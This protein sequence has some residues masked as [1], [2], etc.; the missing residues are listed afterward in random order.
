MPLSLPPLASAPEMRPVV[1]GI[2][3]DSGAG[4]TTLAQGIAAILGAG[5]VALLAADDYR[6]LSRAE[7]RRQGLSALDP[8][9][10]H[11]DILEQHLT[12]LRRGQPVLKPVYDHL[13]GQ[14]APPER[15]EPRPFIIVE[16]ALAYH[17]RALRDGFDV[18]VFAE[19]DEALRRRWKLARD[20]AERGYGPEQ[21]RE[22]LERG[23]ADAQIHI[24]PQRGFADMVVRFAPP[25]A[26]P[27][28]S[29]PRLD[30]RH[31]LRPTLPHPDL[32]PVLDA[33]GKGG[34]RLAL[35]RDG[36]GKPVD[37]LDISGALDGR[38]AQA[39]EDLLWNLIP[40]AAPARGVV[41]R[42]AGLDGKPAASHP[43]ALSQLL[44]TYHLVKATL[45]SD[46]R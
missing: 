27:E 33:G 39:V 24:R 14:P 13:R 29:G 15:L 6:R 21:A 42:H 23:L 16:G 30:V 1:I 19:P 2:V 22:D 7:R 8:A 32:G 41:G 46:P 4:K 36:D 10:S 3:G 11:L 45:A 17:N 5:R 25:E 35:A 12:L 40:G 20:G 31:L 34:F 38:R 28:E 9:A 18:K 43:L 37:V 26:A 44:I